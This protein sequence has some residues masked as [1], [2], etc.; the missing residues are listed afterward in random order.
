MKWDINQV[1][2]CLYVC[3]PRNVYICYVIWQFGSTTMIKGSATVQALR[4]FLVIYLLSYC[5]I[6]AYRSSTIAMSSIGLSISNSCCRQHVVPVVTN[7]SVT[8]MRLN[9]S[10]L[11]GRSLPLL[12]TAHNLVHTG[13]LSCCSDFF[14]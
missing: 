13:I 14:E 9:G 12:L 6:C 11:V 7:T 1:H 10:D 8:V 4:V 3:T 2:V 5:V